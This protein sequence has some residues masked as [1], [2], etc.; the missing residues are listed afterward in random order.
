MTENFGQTHKI[1]RSGSI[2]KLWTFKYIPI[3]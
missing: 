2:S 3:Q 1:F